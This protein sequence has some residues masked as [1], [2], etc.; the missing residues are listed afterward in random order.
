MWSSLNHIYV[1]LRDWAVYILPAISNLILVLLGIIMSLPA[2]A[3]KVEQTSKLWKWLAAI[4]LSFGLTG[5]VFDVGQRRSSDR[6]NRELLGDV[7]VSVSNTKDLV[8]KTDDLLQKTTSLVGTVSVRLPELDTVLGNIADLRVQIQAAREKHDPKLLAGLQEQM[9]QATE[10]ADRI[11]KE[12]RT[13][14]V[15]PRVAS[16]LREWRVNRGAQEKEFRS[17]Q[18]EAELHCT[19]KEGP[20]EDC[21]ALHRKYEQV[22][23]DKERDWVA[24]LGGIISSADSVRAQMLELIPRQRQTTEDQNQAQVFAHGV[25]D[26]E[27]FP[28]DPGAAY[29]ERLALRVPPPQLN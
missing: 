21:G 1:S 17:R 27:S 11:A 6:T 3:E 10:R 4:C 16:D 9:K 19:S 26:P 2:L 15:A 14:T 24:E 7:S 22:Y 20:T 18:Y 13:I 5:F 29:L 12:L 23:A 25:N 28:T 8:R